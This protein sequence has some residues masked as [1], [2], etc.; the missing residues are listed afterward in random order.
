[1]LHDMVR[2]FHG[3]FWWKS[4]LLWAMRQRRAGWYILLITDRAG[5]VAATT[6]C[7]VKCTHHRWTARLTGIPRLT[8]SVCCLQCSDAVSWLAGRAS[9]L[10]KQSS[11]VLA[12]LSVC[13]EVQICIWPMMSLPLTV[14]CS[15]KSRLVGTNLIHG[16]NAWFH[17]R[18]FK[19][20][21]ISRT[22]HGRS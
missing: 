2:K 8:R 12:W 16:E 17:G 6:C 13:G 3:I 1:M 22:I 4:Y 14:S 7:R 11:R 20:C 10:L 19:M 15:S 5:V 21:Q 9:G 18:V